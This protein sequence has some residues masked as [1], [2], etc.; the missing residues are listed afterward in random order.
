M[1]TN[2]HFLSFNLP[3]LPRVQPHQISYA[4]PKH[5]PFIFITLVFAHSFFFVVCPS[6]LSLSPSPRNTFILQDSTQM[7]LENSLNFPKHG[8]MSNG[9]G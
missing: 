8:Y 7:H 4:F 9:M 6:S 3:Y 2:L 1:H 5:T